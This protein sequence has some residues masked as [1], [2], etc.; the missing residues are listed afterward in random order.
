MAV[1]VGILGFVG[2][3]IGQFVWTPRTEQANLAEWNR[4]ISE[5]GATTLGH[6]VKA[7]A[8]DNQEEFGDSRYNIVVLKYEIGGQIYGAEST[9]W[10]LPYM[11]PRFPHVDWAKLERD[12]RES[13]QDSLPIKVEYAPAQPRIFVIPGYTCRPPYYGAGR[14]F[15]YA[16]RTAVLSVFWLIWC[17]ALYALLAGL[18]P[19][20]AMGSGLFTP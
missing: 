20:E 15:F 14:L 12:L 6:V 7:E 11:T 10:W 4:R 1:F 13:G 17:S 2:I 16:L 19:P 8:V 3:V 18:S 9:I 5:Q